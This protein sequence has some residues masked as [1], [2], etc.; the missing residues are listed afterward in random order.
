M[1]L[2][3]ASLVLV[4]FAGACVDTTGGDLVTFGAVAAGPSDAVDGQPLDFVNDRGWHITLTSA[5]LHVGALYLN[6]SVP[7]SGAQNTSCILPGTYVAQVT[8]GAD[9]NLVSPAEQPFPGLGSGVTVPALAGQAWLTGGDIDTVDDTT[10]ILHVEGTADQNG[11]PFAFAGT[12]TIGANRVASGVSGGNPICKQRIVSP[13]PTTVEPRVGGRLRFT[14]DPRLFFVNVDFTAPA[15]GS[16]AFADDS[17]DQP[18]RN[19]YQNLHSSAPY[20]FEWVP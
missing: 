9:V 18:S 16:Y 4:S 15:S 3:V 6:Q 17:S 13:I 19:L 1:K 5:S 11:A 14:V 7:V 12:L 8:M 10:P 20:H 2:R